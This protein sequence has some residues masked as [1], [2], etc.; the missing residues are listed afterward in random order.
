MTRAGRPPEEAETVVLVHGLGS[1]TTVWNLVAPALAERFALVLVD[2]PGHG[3]APLPDG[4]DPLEVMRP[5]ALGARLVRA[6]RELGVPRVHLAGHSLGGWVALEAAAED[7]AA[8]CE[9][10]APVVASVVALAPA[11]L[12]ERPRRRP[13]LVPTGQQFARLGRRLPRSLL[14][15]RWARRLVL[16][17]TSAAPGRLPEEVAL[18]AVTAVESAAGYR[19]ADAGIAAGRFTRGPDV[20]AVAA[21]AF[22]IRDR[23]LPAPRAQLRSA[24]PAACRWLVWDRCGHVP[25]WDRPADCARLIA[26]V[27]AEAAG[28]GG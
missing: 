16:V 7:G 11:G 28:R 17:A 22:G 14:R 8:A 9:G 25:P 26:E 15:R 2:L 13:P 19:A 23:V 4:E 6:C 20:R 21:V 3:A 5:A 10:A 12:W 1:S 24:A 18:D 27:V